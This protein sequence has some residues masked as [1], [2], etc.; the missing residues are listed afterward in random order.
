MSRF[1]ASFRLCRPQAII[2]ISKPSNWGTRSQMALFIWYQELREN[3]GKKNLEFPQ[4][5]GRQDD[6]QSHFGAEIT[7]VPPPLSFSKAAYS[8]T[9]VSQQPASSPD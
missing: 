2:A 3:Q 1:G 6:P 9:Y 4:Q 7:P 5:Y 8:M